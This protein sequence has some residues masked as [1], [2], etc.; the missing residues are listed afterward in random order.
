M[1]NNIIV[2]IDQKFDFQ[3]VIASVKALGFNVIKSRPFTRTISVE[4]TDRIE[5]LKSVPGVK[6][7]EESHFVIEANGKK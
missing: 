1:L 2:T 4:G 5:A 6:T 7:T 3:T